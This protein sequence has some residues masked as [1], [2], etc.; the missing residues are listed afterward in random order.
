MIIGVVGGGVVGRAIAR[1]YFEF[2]ETRVFDIDPN[3]ATH[4]YEQSLEADVIFLCLPTPAVKSGM[5]INTSVLDAFFN[6][7]V[8]S[9]KNFVIRSTTPIGYTKRTAETYRLPNLLHSPE[10]LTSRCSMVDAMMPSRSLIGVPLFLN[11]GTDSQMTLLKLYKK[12]FPEAYL[13]VFTSDETEAVK[14]FTNAFFADKIAIMNEF[15]TL[16]DKLG[17]SW[18]DVRNAMLMD[19]RIHPSHTQVP[20]PDGQLGF[21]G[22]CLPKDLSEMCRMMQELDVPAP[23]CLGA[24]IRNSTLDRKE[25]KQPSGTLPADLGQPLKS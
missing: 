15:K 6:A 13:E 12:R 16:C 2:C 7:N 24:F 23:M 19:G 4:T 8:G 22:S 14:L 17:L 5:G 20:G 9:A 10:F 3:R 18:G 25:A 11:R 21:G 1:S